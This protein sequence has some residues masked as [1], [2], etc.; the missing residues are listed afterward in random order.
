MKRAIRIITTAIIVILLSS[1][2]ALA[3]ETKTYDIKE[4]GLSINLSADYV[5]K[6]EWLDD[7][8]AVKFL[9]FDTKNNNHLAVYSVKWNGSWTPTRIEVLAEEL[10]VETYDLITA[11]G[12]EPIRYGYLD[13]EQTIVLKTYYDM[14]Q[15]Y[16]GQLNKGIIYA[17]LYDDKA[18]FIDVG[19]NESL[20]AVEEKE[21]DRIVKS[22]NFYDEEALPMG[23]SDAVIAAME[24]AKAQEN[25][26]SKIRVIGE[27]TENS[28]KIQNGVFTD[29]MGFCFEMPRN[30]EVDS[31][32]KT[33]E[34]ARYITL[35]PKDETDAYIDLIIIDGESAGEDTLGGLGNRSAM[36][37]EVIKDGIENGYEII[38]RKD[39]NVE[40]SGRKYICTHITGK[41]NVEEFYYKNITIYEY[42]D[43]GWFY[44]VVCG[45]GINEK[46][47]DDVAQA[48][49]ES[50]SLTRKGTAVNNIETEIVED[51]SSDYI[52]LKI[53]IAFI[54]QYAPI[55]IYRFCI[56]K[57]AL[58][59][60]QAKTTALI[61]VGIME[62]IN[63]V[64]CF[65]GNIPIKPIRLSGII[66]MYGICRYILQITDER[67]EEENDQQ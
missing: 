63:I 42:Y 28:Y 33:D 50:V 62:T 37:D 26:V 9:G 56:R 36:A 13:H 67:I 55:F 65:I 66:V 60:G 59:L 18:V 29:N 58:P 31:V 44:A 1:L 6:E 52:G 35:Y 38:E 34:Y 16:K 14:P 11:Q 8:S 46:N 61:Y 30:W 3:K 54:L 43:N 49:A 12:G 10:D 5:V 40:I 21:F 51:N 15:D 39:E 47:L 19:A 41:N 32:E 2:T 17:V 23:Y 7:S 45:T 24:E 25:Y 4:L 64:G 57:R 48:M 53:L 27:G 22:I 20:T